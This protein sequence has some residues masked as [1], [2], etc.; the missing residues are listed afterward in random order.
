G[1]A[2]AQGPQGPQGPGATAFSR[3]VDGQF[4]GLITQ[5]AG[6]LVIGDCGGDYVGVHLQESDPSQGFRAFGTTSTGGTPVSVDPPTDPVSA[7]GGSGS[8]VAD[9]SVV[10]HS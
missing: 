7:G 10:A 3:S 6:V 1:P 9:V 5:A 4:S 2:G 8:T